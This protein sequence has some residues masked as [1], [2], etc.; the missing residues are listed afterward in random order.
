MNK[1]LPIA[2]ALLFALIA[3]QA[4]ATTV[5][6]SQTVTGQACQASSP[7]DDGLI[8]YDFDNGAYNN[9][10][11]AT[12][13]VQCALPMSYIRSPTMATMASANVVVYDTHA[14]LNVSCTLNKNTHLGGTLYWNTQTTSGYSST[15]MVLNFAN[16]IGTADGY[17]YIDCSLP[18]RSSSGS[19]NHVVT[20][21]TSI[22]ETF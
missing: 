12:V 11:T 10:S 7:T 22:T 1:L 20:Y 15:P 9:S 18:P 17:Y 13:S 6:R 16:P 2:S 3:S 14:T 4:S 5:T 19:S 21:A 8:G